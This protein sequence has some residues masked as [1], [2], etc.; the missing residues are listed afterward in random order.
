LASLKTPANH[1]ENRWTEANGTGGS[2]APREPAKPKKRSKNKG[3]PHR[4]II[5]IKGTSETQK[6]IEKQRTASLYPSEPMQEAPGKL[7]HL[8]EQ[9]FI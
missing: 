2:A 1:N 5:G 3:Q 8:T 6:S 4:G 7:H 9:L